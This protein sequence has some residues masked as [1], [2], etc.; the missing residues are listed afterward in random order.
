MHTI[1]EYG[2]KVLNIMKNGLKGDIDK[3]TKKIVVNEREKI[4]KIILIVSF[5]LWTKIKTIFNEY[6]ETGGCDH[7]GS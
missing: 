1:N 6:L 5:H 2:K 3:E 7:R 4:K